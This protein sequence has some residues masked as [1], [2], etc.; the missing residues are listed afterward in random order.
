M[1][2]YDTVPYPSAIFRQAQ[3]ERMAMVARLHGL[4][5]PDPATARY[6]EIGGGDGLHA[7]ALGVAFP[8]ASFV[9]FDLA[10]SAIARGQHWADA[11]GITN[12]R[13]LVLDILEAADQ[14]EG[15][16]D[17]IVA[18]GV[19]AWVPEVVRAAIPR[20]IARLLSPDGV[21]M[22]SYN[23]LPGGYS[24]MAVRGLLRSHLDPDLPPAEALAAAR[25][26]LAE[27]A[28]PQAQDEPII[29][30]MRREAEAMQ[31]RP[32]EVVFHDEMGD[33]YAPQSIGDVAR[34]CAEAGLCYLNESGKGLLR[35]AFAWDDAPEPEPAALVRQLEAL[36]FA[37]G[38]YFRSS[39]FVH[40]DRAPARRIDAVALGGLWASG[41]LRE[42]APGEFV[43]GDTRIEVADAA[44][45]GVLRALGR[46]AP[47]RIA[48]ADLS[49]SYEHLLALFRLVDERMLDLHAVPAPFT[50]T[51]GERPLASPLIRMQIAEGRRV[52]A[53]LD[54][55][56]AEIADPRARAFLALLDGSRDR[57]AL[58]RDFAATGQDGGVTVDAAL[59]MVARGGMLLAERR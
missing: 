30:A 56:S 19:Y 36:D 15:P 24:R 1:T 45:A 51:P 33:C 41:H 14:L 28:V 44:L 10:P 13:H 17:Y 37:Q 34:A 23:A 50:L 57:D 9:N 25:A 40:A 47:G 38:R 4:N 27:F 52:V 49:L 54:H 8:N 20:L 7:M 11:A 53:T 32:G 43:A 16:F 22:I 29:A 26:L 21:A 5:P 39:L 55:R 35:H 42:E 46:E 2:P 59:A 48:L 3:P 12:V 58:A 6:L 31:S 18:H